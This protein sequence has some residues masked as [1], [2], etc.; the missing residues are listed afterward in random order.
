MSRRCVARFDRVTTPEDF[1]T[2]AR[3]LRLIRNAIM[4]D[5]RPPPHGAPQPYLGILAAFAVFMT[6]VW[7]ASVLA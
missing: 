4:T 2:R 6:V 5:R 3:H 1:E 7:I